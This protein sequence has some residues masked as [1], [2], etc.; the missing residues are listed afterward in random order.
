MN[1]SVPCVTLGIEEQPAHL[2][3][4]LPCSILAPARWVSQHRQK[5]QCR[6]RFRKPGECYLMVTALETPRAI[7]YVANATDARDEGSTLLPTL[8][9]VSDF[10]KLF[11][12]DCK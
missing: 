12:D 2:E 10:N 7:P 1:A 11:E 8:L 9:L 4:G 3:Q 5:I 6:K